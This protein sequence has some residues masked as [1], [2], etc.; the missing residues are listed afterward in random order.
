MTDPDDGGFD[1]MGRTLKAIWDRAKTELRLEK[2][3]M[4]G[5]GER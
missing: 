4:E 3:E 1:C 5:I 2:G